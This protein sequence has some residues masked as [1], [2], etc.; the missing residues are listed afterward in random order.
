MTNKSASEDM[1]NLWQS[2]PTESPKIRPED[3]RPK[4]DRF[5]RRI[6]WRN[7]REYAASVVVIAIL[8]VEAPRAA[9]SR[10]FRTHYCGH[11]V[12]DAPASSACVGTDCAGGPGI[13]HVHRFPSE[14]P[15][16]SAGR[17]AHDLVMVPGAVCAGPCGVRDWIGDEPVEG[18][19]GGP[20]T[21]YHW[22]PCLPGY[23]GGSLF[24]NL[25]TKPMGRREAAEADR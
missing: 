25:E 10:G 21:L 3:F 8:R 7:L 4:M 2:Q 22:L 20:G 23:Y 1:K 13:E 14:I 11:A 18:A 16:A 24:R 5:E 17:I 6:F 19:P 12:C 15:A 9:C